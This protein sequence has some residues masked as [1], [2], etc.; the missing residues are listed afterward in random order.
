MPDNSKFFNLQ[1]TRRGKWPVFTYTLTLYYSLKYVGLLAGIVGAIVFGF[2]PNVY[3]AFF[4]PKME[5]TVVAEEK[6]Y[7]P[8]MV[9]I[10]SINLE[11]PVKEA[12]VSANNWEVFDGAVSWLK[13]S[14]TMEKGNIVL[15][16]HNEKENFGKIIQ[17]KV[18]DVIVVRNQHFEKWFKV[19]KGVEIPSSDLSYLQNT[20]DSLTMY[21]C[22]GWFDSKRYFV[23]AELLEG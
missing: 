9:I 22:S 14:G 15:Y 21:T 1:I 11:M 23:I 2:A 6:H 5:T 8:D 18:G 13:T 10:P 20:Q 3:V 7:K 12:S 16:G 4:T 17:L 19:T